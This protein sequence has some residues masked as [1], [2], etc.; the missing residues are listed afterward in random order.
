MLV[1]NGF[2][3]KV[4]HLIFDLVSCQAELYYGASTL[5]KCDVFSIIQHSAVIEVPAFNA[6]DS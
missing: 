2:S 4:R 3:H 1:A 6:R 5:Y